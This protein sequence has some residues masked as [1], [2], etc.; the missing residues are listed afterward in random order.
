[1]Q[2]TE[3]RSSVKYQLKK[4]LCL[5]VAVGNV[6]MSERELY[7]NI[8]VSRRGILADSGAESQITN[9]VQCNAFLPCLG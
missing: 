1:M 4:V 5:G 3:I 7:I 8:Q 9:H 6:N 2:A